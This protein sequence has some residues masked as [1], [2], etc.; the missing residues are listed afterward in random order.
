M[1][2]S[3]VDVGRFGEI[4]DRHAPAI[5]RFLGRRIGPDDAGDLLSEVFLAAF[6]SRMGYDRDRPS[7]LPWLYGIASNLLN[8]HYRHRASELRGL[9]RMLVESDPHDHAESVTAWVDAQLQL[10]AMAKL[11]EELPASERDALLLYA[12]EDLT[13]GEIAGA[14]GVPTGTVRSRLSRVRQRLRAA[15]D[16]I[17]GVR[18]VR[19]DR[20]TP[21]PDA[22]ASLFDRERERLMQAIDEGKTK[23][24]I[25]DG[26][27][28]V[29]IRS[30][31]DITAGDGARRDV[32]DGKAVSSTTTTCNIF[33]LLN[34]L[35]VPTHF[36][37]QLDAV[38]FRA[39]RVEM[40][41]LELVAR[42]IATG[43]ILD[44]NADIADGTVLADLVFEV[45]EKDDANHDPLLEFDFAGDALRRLV[46]NT[47]AA[48]ELGVHAGDVIRQEPLSHSRYATVTSEL[49]ERLRELTLRTFE[50]VEEAWAGLGGTYF[51]FKIEC[52]FDH[53]NGTLL[54]ADVIDSDSGRLRFGDKDMSKQAYRD[55]SQSLPDIKQNFDE[56]AELTKQFV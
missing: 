52:G 5:F 16:E 27:G 8:K 25:D 9:E 36:L 48:I 10:R 31:D 13:Y 23:I 4:Y 46:P 12:W 41:P 28:T 19:P 17:D 18:S 24:I 11:L 3:L 32:I 20:L 22:P 1:E 56:V 54:V 15:T 40:I 30:K 6:E 49:L 7:A 38:T 39:R 34:R 43:S 44:R 33:R 42:R 21:L 14:L 29:L 35:G 45:F 2:A 53:E 26:D 50:I 55:G 51:D 37:E 47:K